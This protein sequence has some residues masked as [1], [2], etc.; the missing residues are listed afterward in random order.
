MDDENGAMQGH[1]EINLLTFYMFSEEKS[2]CAA[3]C[4]IGAKHY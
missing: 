2:E 1:G 3:H 4:A